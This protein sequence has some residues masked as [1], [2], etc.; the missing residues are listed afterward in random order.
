MGLTEDGIVYSWGS[1]YSAAPVTGHGSSE[2]CPVPTRVEGLVDQKIVLIA[3]GWDHSMAVTEEGAVFSWG[4][5]PGGCLGHVTTG[6]KSTPH[7][8]TTLAGEKISWLA[9]GQ[10]KTV[11]ICSKGTCYTWGS[12]G[13]HL[14]RTAALSQPLS[15]SSATPALIDEPPAGTPVSKFTFACVLN[16]STLVIATPT[17]RLFPYTAATAF[18]IGGN[19]EATDMNMHYPPFPVFAA[20]TGHADD[21]FRGVSF[22]N[23]GNGK[24]KSSN[25]KENSDKSSNS[26]ESS[27]SWDYTGWRFF[28]SKHSPG[29]EIEVKT[30]LANRIDALITHADCLPDCKGFSTDGAIKRTIK[31][32]SE[33]IDPHW[34]PSDRTG[35][36]VKMHHFLDLQ[37]VSTDGGEFGNVNAVGN[38]LTNNATTYRSKVKYATVNILTESTSGSKVCPTKFSVI[39]PNTGVATVK[40][41]LVFILDNPSQVAATSVYDDYDQEQYAAY[42]AKYLL[43]EIQPTDPVAFFTVNRVAGKISVEVDFYRS[44][45]YIL[46]K[47]LN[48]GGVADT[49]SQGQGIITQPGHT[50]SLSHHTYSL[51]HHTYYFS[52]HA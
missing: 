31:D 10:N 35:M 11:A 41:G 12:P 52:H 50:Y 15:V 1:G 22:S 29:G 28:P 26:K 5:D 8:I 2:R 17:P 44:G 19:A 38:I 16:N 48:A 32:P 27:G 40:S 43:A 37:V 6:S 24:D 39:A 51:S 18:K 33:W 7:L 20:V 42:T 36:F 45:K 30:A 25:S 9:G 13:Q 3:A 46:L 34:E 21:F 4:D 14:G 23:T 49:H 47:L